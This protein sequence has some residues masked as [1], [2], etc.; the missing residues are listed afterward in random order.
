[1][2]GAPWKEETGGYRGQQLPEAI[3]E[4]HT[5]EWNGNN[6]GAAKP[7]SDQAHLPSERKDK[8]ATRE[9]LTRHRPHVPEGPT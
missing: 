3:S 9:M 6:H 4:T 1:M 7:G 2:K 8:Q 5:K